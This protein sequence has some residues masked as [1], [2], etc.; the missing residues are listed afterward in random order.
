MRENEIFV[1]VARNIFLYTHCGHL[2]L[3]QKNFNMAHKTQ[4]S[5]SFL[6]L[7]D[8]KIMCATNNP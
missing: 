4:K 8:F 7:S 6:F 5:A 2:I 1:N 3:N